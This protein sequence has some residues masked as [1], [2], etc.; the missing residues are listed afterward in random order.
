MKIKTIMKALLIGGIVFCIGLYL[1]SC[2]KTKDKVEELT[3]LTDPTG[4]S[5]DMDT[6]KITWEFVENADYYLV[7]F[8]EEAETKVYT[9]NVTYSSP[10]DQFTFNITAKSEGL[11]LDSNTVSMTFAKLPSEITMSVADDGKVTW[12]EVNGATGYEVMVDGVSV[13]K[14]PTP[15]YDEV[16]VGSTHS[17]KVKPVK[18]GTPNVYYYASWSSAASV[19]KLGTT[20]I[21][22]ITYNN[23]VLKWNAVT[24]ATKY[25][26][27]IN[28]SPYETE[29]NE[30]A[31]DAKKE[32]FNVTVQ[33]IGNHTST[34]DGAVSE[35]KSF[36][37][38]SMV[39]DISI[40][41]GN[42][43]WG[44]VDQATSYQIKL[45]NQNSTPVATTETTYTNLT[46]GTQYEIR[47]LPVGSG[48]NT[49]YFSDWSEALPVYILPAP[50]ITWTAGLDVDG[51]DK[52]NA[53][54]WNIIS[55]AAGY[56]YHVTLPNEQVE[57]GTLGG[58]NN[59]YSS[60]FTETG[61]Y[62][63]KVKATADGTAGIYDSAYSTPITVKRLEAP[64]ISSSNIASTPNNLA[65]G[66]TVTFDRVM[67]ATSYR[68][69]QNETSVQTNTQAQFRVADI[70]EESNTREVSIAYYVQ[71]IGSVSSDGKTVILSSLMGAASSASAFNITVLATPSNPTIIGNT[72]YSATYQFD[73]VSHGF[74]YNVNVSGRNLTATNTNFNLDSAIEA[75]EYVVSVCTQ[76]NGHE[77][78]ASTYAPAIN[79]TRLNAPT[80]LKISTD[81][82]DGALSFD[83]DDLSDSY[84]LLITGRSEALPVDQGTNIKE[85]ITTQATIIHMYS[86][87][88]RFADAQQT[89]YY[90]TSRASQTYTFMKLEAPSKINFDNTS[91]TWNAPSNLNST[92]SS[93]TPA[94]KILD[95][96]DNT[97]Y[98][99]EFRGLSYPLTHFEAGVYS[100]KIIAVGDGENYINSDAAESR[101][102]RKLA[103]PKF[104]VNTTNG[105]YEWNSVAGT[106]NYILQIDNELVS[107][108][109]HQAGELN[110]Y[111]PTYDILGNHSVTLFASGDGGT[112]TINSSTFEYTQ[113]VEQLTT[114]EFVYSY[115]A[116]SFDPQAKIRVE[117]SKAAPYATGYQY[118]IGGTTHF[119]DESFEFNPN[120]AGSISIYVYAKGGGFDEK[121]V[122]YSD[123][124]SAATVNLNLLGYPTINNE[125][126]SKD[127][128]LTW[129]SVSGAKGY[130]YK[131]IIT[132]TDN[133]TYTIE[134]VINTNRAS[135]ELDGL[136]YTNASGEKVTLSYQTVM[137]LTVEI[138]AKGDLEANTTI[139][140]DASVSSEKTTISWNSALHEP[141]E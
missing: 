37:Y 16:E 97:A 3:S 66:F 129:G 6:S 45:F 63:V 85:H 108:E 78:L 32:G 55:Q 30:Y 29:K 90:M 76:G 33:A 42:L 7:S 107:N 88:N 39:Q 103:T 118:V 47:I 10:N 73:E 111:I 27:T 69:Y 106:S 114:P 34:Y 124:R 119:S 87:A 44:K 121:E 54:N 112:T 70:V 117:I 53:I 75:G 123:S 125:N 26:L 41:N 52:V 128:I 93:F 139:N 57:E 91:M 64:T 12:N 122:Y 50:Q 82:S 9:N 25:K 80:N 40:E 5:Y 98:N 96:T 105:R 51:T 109:I 137:Y 17:I 101:E 43:V 89:R 132:G 28:G 113:V 74:G 15:V 81:E 22:S 140:R 46:S 104:K 135:L 2:G 130:I 36:V 141:K 1:S 77:I 83:G 71:S 49:T 126:L 14:V 23:G 24:S 110:Y 100:F 62:V 18:E 31:F 115:G 99:G 4:I 13:G 120:T 56:A 65:S 72:D 48:E 19:N 84:D 38:L 134:G 92:S 116:V 79:V 136:S 67:G 131:L 86:I 102:I 35:Q 95:A 61:T 133:E 58:A 59:F 8:G 68:L 20:P 60:A 94:Y 138:Q 127:G 21:N 11:F